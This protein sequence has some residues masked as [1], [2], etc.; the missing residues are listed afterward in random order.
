MLNAVPDRDLFY[1]VGVSTGSSSIVGMFPVWSELLGI[2]ASLVGRDLPLT[3]SPASYR[4]VVE[5]IAGTPRAR[6]AL[7]TTHKIG[8]FRHADDLFIEL[9]ENAR[10]CA[11]VSC[12]AKRDGR[13]FG[14]A[15]D[16]ITGGRTLAEMIG[17]D[18]FSREPAAQVLCLGAGGAGVALTTCLLSSPHPPARVVLTDIDEQRLAEAR[19]GLGGTVSYVLGSADGLVAALPPGSM[20]INATGMGKDRPGSPLDGTAVFPERG[21]VWELNYRGELRFLAQAKAQAEHRQLDVQDGWRY[22]LHG[23]AE[24]IAEVFDLDLSP[25]QFAELAA[26]SEPFR[27]VSSGS[28]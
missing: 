2:D 5:E 27:P 19:A 14:Y 3:A 4:A 12:I 20:V 22:F 15:K 10:L 21:I 1:F 8:I 28:I 13:L 26:V 9:D 6:G 16:P 23:W 24:H 18:Y 11:E 17:D 7:V 25:A